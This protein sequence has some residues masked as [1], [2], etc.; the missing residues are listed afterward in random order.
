[1]ALN[2]KKPNYI[3]TSEISKDDSSKVIDDL[4]F[5]H[6]FRILKDLLEKS[7]KVKNYDL[8]Q[9][10]EIQNK[11]DET[12]GLNA[13]VDSLKNKSLITYIDAPW[14]SGKT[15]FVENLINWIKKPGQS[16]EV[17]FNFHHR[18]ETELEIDFIDAWEINNK[19]TI[20]E[21][22]IDAYSIDVEDFRDFL[23]K[24]EHINK[25]VKRWA[26]RL[27]R[28]A[29]TIPKRIL[30]GSNLRFSTGSISLGLNLESLLNDQELKEAFEKPF[31][32]E[33][34][35]FNSL[36]EEKKLKILLASYIEWK[37]SNNNKV[38]VIDNIERLDS[39]DR[40]SVINTILNWAN[41][42]GTTFIFLT[43][44]EKI[45]ITKDFEEDFWNKISLHET[46]K[47]TNNWQN[48]IENYSKDNIIIS[49]PALIDL[50]DFILN[51]IP[52]FFSNNEDNMDIREI[53][54]LLDNW[55]ANGRGSKELII[56]LL[57]EVIEKNL[58]G[59]DKYFLINHSIT[60]LSENKW[61]LW[62]E[63][64]IKDSTNGD[65]DTNNIP[66]INNKMFRIQSNF[67]DLEVESSGDEIKFKNSSNLK[68]SDNNLPHFNKFNNFIDDNASN[69]FRKVIEDILRTRVINNTS[70]YIYNYIKY[71]NNDSIKY[72]EFK[73]NN[74]KKLH[75]YNNIFK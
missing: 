69:S 28:I 29:W 16:G 35:I 18:N 5:N 6:P 74:I 71:K 67:Y 56:S 38:I 22:L 40:L 37:Y 39:K 52:T 54:K 23:I 12:S 60:W 32:E 25:K 48:Y 17:L 2:I 45:K 7:W 11:F 1:M 9:G 47:L 21:L 36:N 63:D 19:K 31:K 62:E 27:G 42:K 15:Y 44:F 75:I 70:N 73:Y 26:K 59:L 65:S 53:K 14:G 72:F 43:N 4:N 13:T 8:K 10:E 55:D 41:L 57:K 24:D 61:H 3:N 64:G 34:E 58:E 49:D 46:F 68:I 33:T 66:L 50:K 30:K 20:E 51:T